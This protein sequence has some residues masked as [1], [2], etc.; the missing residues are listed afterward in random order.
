MTYTG[1]LMK[2]LQ[3]IVDAC[4]QTDARVCAI[5]HQRYGDHSKDGARCPVPRSAGPLYLQTS[6]VERCCKGNA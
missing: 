3:T 2:D 4:L 6:F 5:C 1:T